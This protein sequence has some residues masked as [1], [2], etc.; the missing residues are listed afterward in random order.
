MNKAFLSYFFSY[1]F[2][3]KTRQRLVF[4][5][6][7]GLFLSSFSLIVLH[8]VMGGLQDGLI[9]RSKNVEGHFV[10]QILGDEKSLSTQ[11]ISE[12]STA[13]IKYFAEYEIEL[14]ARNEGRLTPIILHGVDTSKELAPFLQQKDMKG[15]ILGADLGSKLQADFF[16]Q[17][18]LIS[19]AHTDPI[20]GDIPR[21]VGVD[22]TDFFSSEL[23]EIDL[24]NAWVRL[25]LVQNLIRERSMNTIRFYDDTVFEKVA[26][27]VSEIDSPFLKLEKWE[28]KHEALVW[29]LGL[30]TTVM[31][32]LFVCMTFLISITIT[33]GFL[34]F[35]DKIKKDLAS[36]WILGS[37]K[38]AIMKMASQF[39]NLVSLLTCFL[40]LAAGLLTLFLLDNYSTN[41]MPDVFMERSL[42]INV[43]ASGIAISVFIPYLI[44]VS[45]SLF[46]LSHF[47]R[48]NHSFLEIVRNVG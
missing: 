5:A 28:D 39:C 11:L 8:S 2:H 46:S 34:I 3:S 35:F 31:L 12:L 14:L 43:T 17:I 18:N 6:I 41:I 10:V 7:A 32:I 33:A 27:I 22:V 26:S 1:L 16:T 42:P 23:T 19:P 29:S 47:K 9:R 48:E 44:S 40:G 20:L 24:F 38:E 15:I 25:P 45:F 4:I 30:E 37:S 21:Q 36:F 13:N